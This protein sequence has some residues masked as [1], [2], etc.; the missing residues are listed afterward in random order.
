MNMRGFLFGLKAFQ[1]EPRKV[2]ERR[3]RGI[4]DSLPSVILKARENREASVRRKNKAAV[5]NPKADF[6]EAIHFAIDEAKRVGA[7]F[8]LP[9]PVRTVY[10]V[11]GVQ[12]I[13]D[14][15]G[16]QYFFA[17]DWE[18]QPPY[19]IFID[20]YRAIGAEA[21]AD[22]LAAAVAS[23]PFADPHKHQDQRRKFMEQFL[24]K[25]GGTIHRPDSPFELYDICGRKAVWHLLSEYISLHSAVFPK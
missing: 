13:I 25:V 7:P 5:P 15:G 19:S 11:Q 22:A 17:W 14:N 10:F 16:L 18:G 20:A 4:T 6:D 8:K 3:E 9:E 2:S 12:G 1:C 21:E 23:F 24:R